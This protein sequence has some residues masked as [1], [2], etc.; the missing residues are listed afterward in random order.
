MDLEVAIAGVLQERSALQQPEGL[1]NPSYISE[2][3]QALSQY[4]AALDDAVREEE[5]KLDIHES[6]LFKKY[7]SEGKSVNASQVQIRYDMMADRAEITNL[8]RLVS[9]SWKFINAC[10]SRLKHLVEEAKN[11]I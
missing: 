8:N 5:K 10:Q 11:Q 3:M 6:K 7:R 1:S 4:V 2:H 9:G